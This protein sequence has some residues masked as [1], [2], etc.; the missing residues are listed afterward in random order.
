MSLCGT[1][2]FSFFKTALLAAALLTAGPASAQEQLRIGGTGGALAVMKKLASGFQRSHPGIT[3]AV[4][5]SLGSAGGIKAVLAGALDLSVSSRPLNASEQGVAA[6]VM[7]RT[8]F[9]FVVQRN[10]PVSALTMEEL[11]ALYAGRTRNW[12]DGRP[13]RI[14]LRQEAESDTSLLKS[15]SPGMAR[16]V[17][18]ALSREG[19]VMAITD[20]DNANAIETIPGAI[21][22]I[23][24]GQLLCEER[25]F[26]ILSL[27][28]LLPGRDT[29]AP[30]AYP[31]VKTYYLVMKSGA[32]GALQEFTDFIF[33]ARGRAILSRCGYWTVR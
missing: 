28:G 23:S 22:A 29:T 10:S 13:V 3:I 21:G 16:S 19:M 17:T 9:V 27:N 32:R 24:L 1:M 12:P 11:E 26:T 2:P 8:P 31:Y 14:V 18:E 30:G 20:H 5:P 6:R 25:P 15:M 4:L 7:G 33:S